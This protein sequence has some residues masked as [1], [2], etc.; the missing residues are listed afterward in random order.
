MVERDD[1]QND[2]LN[3]Q[4]IRAFLER[5]KKMSLWCD[6]AKNVGPAFTMFDM[7]GWGNLFRRAP[8]DGTFLLEEIQFLR[9]AI[10]DNGHHPKPAGHSRA[11]KTYYNSKRRYCCLHHGTECFFLEKQCLWS[12]KNCLSAK[13]QWKLMYFSHTGPLELILLN[14]SG[15]IPMSKRENWF[16]TV[17]SDWD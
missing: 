3:V 4:T 7:N 2:V 17:V 5:P 6:M 15:P 1:D 8:S 9:E 13:Y 10:V 11:N 14:K 16:K 12:L